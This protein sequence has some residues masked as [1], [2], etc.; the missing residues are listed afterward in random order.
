[1]NLILMTTNLII[2]NNR[3]TVGQLSDLKHK[4]LNIKTPPSDSPQ[5][6]YRK[7]TSKSIAD[8]I[9]IILLKMN[10]LTH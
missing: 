2:K 9:C 5:K 8:F 6:T 4:I 1:M 10:I 3:T 7:D